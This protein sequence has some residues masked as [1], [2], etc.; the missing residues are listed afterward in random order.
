M[1]WLAV[2]VAGAALLALPAQA[3]ESSG[4]AKLTI[5]LLA[6]GGTFKIVSDKAPKGRPSKGDVVHERTTLKNLVRQFGKPKGAVVG[7]DL[8]VVTFSSP[9]T[10][11]FVLTV[12]LPGGTLRC[13][14]RITPAAESTLKVVGGT[15]AFAGARGTGVVRAAPALKGAYNT[16]RLTLP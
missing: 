13:T 9:S 15:G 11:N 1:R 16:Y 5:R 7:S 6:V 12:K 3:A 14:S 10:A 4:S 2:A 8:A